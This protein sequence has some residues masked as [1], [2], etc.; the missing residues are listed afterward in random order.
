MILNDDS[1]RA[2]LD[3]VTFAW[4]FAWAAKGVQNLLSRKRDSVSS[5]FIT[6]F[7][8]CGVPLLLDH[9]FGKPN[10]Q[11]WR[12]FDIAAADGL[13]GLV[14]CLYVSAC[15]VIWW[16]CGRSKSYSKADSS[17]SSASAS[18]RHLSWQGQITLH[19]ALI[20]PL[21]ALYLAPNPRI[22]FEYAAVVRGSFTAE[23]V[24]Y[25]TI[26]GALIMTS[27][28][29]GAALLFSQR[30]LKFTCCYV[31]PFAVLAAWVN[32]KRSVVLLVIVL[33]G[34]ALWLRG[35]LRK[36]TLMVLAPAMAI[37]F[38]IFSTSYQAEIRSFDAADGGQRYD[39]MRLDYG[40]DHVIRLSLYAEIHRDSEPILEH[41]MQSLLFD[42]T[43][44]VPR[45]MWPEKPWPYATYA[46]AAA[47]RLPVRNFGWGITTSWLEEAVANFGWP[48]LIIGPLLLAVICRVGDATKDS[49]VRLLTILVGSQLLVVQ[50]TAF[51][52]FVVIW[53]I[54]ILASRRVRRLP[55]VRL[56]STNGMRVEGSAGRNPGGSMPFFPP[57]LDACSG[58]GV[59]LIR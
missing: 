33:F 5:L 49:I 48:G 38:W 11:V 46:T 30:R 43:M 9:V 41:R 12:G 40:R 25:Q 29:A 14:Y 52:P 47:L 17:K 8:F 21:L 44:L 39:N 45:K 1:L 59:R 31:L 22:Y 37:A 42:A 27:I 7:V 6:H 20:S 19:M 15:P 2:I 26:F 13:T 24:A 58:K 28:I 23:E 36:R 50:M 53:L 57:V 32:G 4:L 55:A 34:S 56:G 51:V 35:A 10:Y 18:L 54:A 3:I 16:Y